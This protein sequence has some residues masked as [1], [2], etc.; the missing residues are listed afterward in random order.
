M[1]SRT[2]LTTGANSGIGL[3]AVLAV[4]RSG[5]RSLG[6]VR[7]EAKA[8][9]VRKAA[10][11]AGVE[12]DTVLLDVA[13]AGQCAQVMEGLDLYGL[14]NNAGYGMVGAIED[15]DDDEARQLFETMVFAP[16]RLARLALPGMR[17]V[18]GGRIVNVSSVMGRVTTPF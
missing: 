13:D 17:A 2:V 7:T 12:V 4:A 14:V 5:F 10:A 16:M 1:A 18:G 8:D 3:A 11:D 9:T 15:I 6:S